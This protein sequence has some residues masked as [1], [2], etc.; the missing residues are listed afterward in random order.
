M[1]MSARHRIMPDVKHPG[2]EPRFLV[3]GRTAGGRYASWSSPR[4]GEAGVCSQGAIGVRFMHEKEIRK[5]EQE[6]ARLQNR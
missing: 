4:V 5:Y 3:M 6:A 1:L 2:V